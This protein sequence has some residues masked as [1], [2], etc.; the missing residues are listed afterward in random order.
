MLAAPS[1][2][3][4]RSPPRMWPD[5]GGS[6]AAAAAPRR[7]PPPA[8]IQRRPASRA[9]TKEDPPPF[10][11]AL[12]G[13]AGELFNP[14]GRITDWSRAGYAG[15]AADIPSYPQSPAFNVRTFGAMADGSGVQDLPGRQAGG[16][17]WLVV[18]P[19][20]SPCAAIDKRS[21]APELACPT[22]P[23][24]P[25][26]RRRTSFPA[27]HQCRCAGGWPWQ[28][29][30]GVRAGRQAQQPWCRPRLIRQSLSNRCLVC[31]CPHHLPSV[32]PAG[33][34]RWRLPIQP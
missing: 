32:P 19:A 8:P 11:S 12:W 29:Q 4:S 3:R 24:L 16:E 10:Y 14:A 21:L 34:S 15:G 31:T 28:R 33:H 13:R 23:R 17:E 1:Q 27:C 2:N 6:V 9:G 26:R 5:A 7:P 22:A 25:A 20:S 18:P 30:G